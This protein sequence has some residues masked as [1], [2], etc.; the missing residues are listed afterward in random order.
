MNEI[1]EIQSSIHHQRATMKR[2]EFPTG[3]ERMTSKTSGRASELQK[4]N[5][6]AQLLSKWPCLP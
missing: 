4:D 5:E 1:R 2:S 3:F 6:Q